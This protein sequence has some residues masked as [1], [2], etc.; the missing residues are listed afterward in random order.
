[1]RK[2]TVNDTATMNTLIDAGI[3]GLITDY[4]NVLREVMTQH[5]FTLPHPA[6]AN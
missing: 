6:P 1:V 2:S 4:P 3:D 5:G